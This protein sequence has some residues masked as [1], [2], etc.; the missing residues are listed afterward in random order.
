GDVVGVGGAVE[1]VRLLVLGQWHERATFDEECVDLPA[2][3]LRA[4]HP[5]DLI[6]T[7][8]G[9]HLLH[10]GCELG[11]TGGPLRAGHGHALRSRI[12]PATLPALTANLTP[13]AEDVTRS[14]W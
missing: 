13:A 7:G 2:L 4:G 3:L 8:L 5:D 12:W 6:R 9:G 11:V 1:G 14:T 10:P